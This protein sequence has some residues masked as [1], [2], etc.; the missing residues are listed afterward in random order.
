MALRLVGYVLKF[1]RYQLW[2]LIALGTRLAVVK[3]EKAR[4]TVDHV[5]IAQPAHSMISHK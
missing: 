1:F 4:P 3:I 2:W 5:A